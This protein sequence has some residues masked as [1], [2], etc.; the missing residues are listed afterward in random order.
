[1]GYEGEKKSWEVVVKKRLRNTVPE[2]SNLK[3]EA[4]QECMEW[5]VMR[6]REVVTQWERSVP[7]LQ[8]SPVI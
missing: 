1:M 4:Q 7:H 8:V 3:S 2:N 5:P 6:P